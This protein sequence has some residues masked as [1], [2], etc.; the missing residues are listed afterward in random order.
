MPGLAI[1]ISSLLILL[2]VG[3]AAAQTWSGFGANDNWSTGANWGGGVAPPSSSTTQLDFP[4]FSSRRTPFVDMPW[5]V[6]RMAVA[7]NYRLSGQAIT[8]SGANAM[9]T[10]P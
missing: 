8:F 9:L 2:F 1:R 6:N 5:T 10:V 4:L 3:H 7:G